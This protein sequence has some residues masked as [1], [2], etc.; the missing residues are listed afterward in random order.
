MKDK[1]KKSNRTKE[2]AGLKI[3][4][5]EDNFEAEMLKCIYNT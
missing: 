4:Q 5:K 3:V 2:V 1:M